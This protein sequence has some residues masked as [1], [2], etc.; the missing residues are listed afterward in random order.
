MGISYD[1]DTHRVI[2][3]SKVEEWLGEKPEME[4]VGIDVGVMS[5][6]ELKKTVEK[7][8]ERRIF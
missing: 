5:D 1:E 3:E 7:E 4:R 6:K 2:D 8:R